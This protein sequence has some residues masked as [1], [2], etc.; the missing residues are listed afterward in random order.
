MA[1]VSQT[2]S[3]VRGTPAAAGTISGMIAIIPF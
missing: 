1:A 2:G 3:A